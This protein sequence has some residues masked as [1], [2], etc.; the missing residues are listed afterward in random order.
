MQFPGMAAVIPKVHEP[1]GPKLPAMIADA[2]RI[3]CGEVPGDF[4]R[5]P[6]DHYQSS[7]SV[8]HGHTP[9]AV[10]HSRLFFAEAERRLE[11]LHRPCQ[12]GP[13]R[14]SLNRDSV[15]LRNAPMLI[16][17]TAAS[18]SAA[19]VALRPAG[20]SGAF[21]SSTSHTTT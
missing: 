18:A 12:F 11:D 2:F 3:R 21:F 5:I 1:Y 4:T 10:G 15:S 7:N 8:D 20:L 17:T 14:S 9:L 13:P 6:E 16:A 19:N